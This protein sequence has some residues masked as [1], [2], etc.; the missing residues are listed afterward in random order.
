MR[1]YS[2]IPKWGVKDKVK[3][4]RRESKSWNFVRLYTKKI[5]LSIR[6]QKLL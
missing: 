3:F 5:L 4:I 6:E 1:T 2:T